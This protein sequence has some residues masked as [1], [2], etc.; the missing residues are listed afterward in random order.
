MLRNR[1]SESSAHLILRRE[2]KMAR[3]EPKIHIFP[4]PDGPSRSAA[5]TDSSTATKP[6]PEKGSS[7]APKAESG[8][9]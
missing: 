5:Q 6:E 4:D 1:S 3:S 7:S 8:Q 2:L 9:P